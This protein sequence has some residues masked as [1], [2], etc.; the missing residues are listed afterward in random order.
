MSALRVMSYQVNCCTGGRGEP[1]TDLCARVI[2]SQSPDLVFLQQVGSRRDPSQLYQLANLLNMKP[3]GLGQERACCFLS[4]HPLR[5][6]QDYSLGA[7]G[8]CLRA[9][10]DYSGQRLHL[11]NVCLDF[12]P[13]HRKKQIDA[14]LGEELL[15]NPALPCAAL[16]AGDF[17]LPLWGAGQIRLG[18]CLKRAP[19]PLWRANFPADFPLWGRDRFYF[20]GGI[21]A[22]AGTIVSTPEAR[23]ASTHLPL[24][25][26]VEQVE[27]RNF[28]RLKEVPRGGMKPATG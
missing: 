21:T 10:L 6:M 12:N 5:S 24:V 26:T 18:S 23:R 28:L 19:Q 14:L 27:N 4:R 2:A 11:F 3:F 1:T 17:S 25:L 8:S 22:L 16:V 15:G 9:D 7:D 13:L 20:R